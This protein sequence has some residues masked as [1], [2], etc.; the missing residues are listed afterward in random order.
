MNIEKDYLSL[1][2]FTIVFID[3]RHTEFQGSAQKLN[4]YI[5]RHP[6][7]HTRLHQPKFAAKMLEMAAHSNNMRLVVR[8]ADHQV[9]HDLHYV[10]LN[11]VFTTDEKMWQFINHPDNLARVKN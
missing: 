6:L 1:M 8:K 9:K 4:E 2:P 11:G 10:I 5:D 3:P 7:S